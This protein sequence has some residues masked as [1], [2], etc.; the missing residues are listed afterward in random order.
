MLRAVPAGLGALILVGVV[1]TFSPVNSAAGGKEGSIGDRFHEETE[2]TG[3]WMR[4]GDLKPGRDNSKNDTSGA[5]KSVRLPAPDYRGIPL[6]ETLQRRRSV[7]RYADTPLTLSALSQLL[8]AAQGKTG[9]TFGHALRTAPSA[10]ALYP[11]EVYVVVNNVEGVEQGVYRYDG[12]DHI[13]EPVKRGDFRK[14]IST[15]GLGQ[16]FLGEANA[17]FVLTAVFDRTRKNYGE[18]GLRYIY[19]EAGHC[20]QNIALQ[21]VSLGLGSVSVVAFYD[22][23][24]N[25]LVD[26]DGEKESAVYLHAVGTI[27]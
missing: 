15:A 8:F 23:T 26:I 6:E 16:E 7:R 3:R 13:L 19:M 2:L 22:K 14:A 17:T 1:L 9:S 21:A 24:V 10:G 12:D 18:R 5:M 11:L 27:E 20:S 4:S 25:E